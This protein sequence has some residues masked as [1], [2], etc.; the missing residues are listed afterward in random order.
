MYVTAM[1]LPGI[2]FCCCFYSW[3]QCANVI[4]SN[5]YRISE[6]SGSFDG[7][8]FK[9]YLTKD[10]RTWSIL[11]FS[12]ATL[13]LYALKKKKKSEVFWK[14]PK[15]SV[16]ETVS[17]VRAGCSCRTVFQWPH[18]VTVQRASQGQSREWYEPYVWMVRNAIVT[19]SAEARRALSASRVVHRKQSMSDPSI[20]SCWPFRII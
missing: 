12:P 15:H 20:F 9:L 5:L 7:V 14:S 10:V 4:G 2:Q 8:K 11:S 18:Q 17:G 16:T 6:V 3:L 19:H 13:S 1:L